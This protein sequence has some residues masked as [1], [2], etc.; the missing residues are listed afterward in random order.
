MTESSA[1]A[2]DEIVDD[3]AFLPHGLLNDATK[4]PQTK[5]VEQ[6]VTPRSM[7]KH[8]GEWLVDAKSRGKHKVKPEE[9]GEHIT[10]ARRNHLLRHEEDDVDEEEI[11]GDG[12]DIF[13]HKRGVSAVLKLGQG[14][15]ER[16]SEGM[17]KKAA[18]TKM[19]DTR[20]LYLQLRVYLQL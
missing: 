11:A 10:I 2:A 14:M 19:K 16:Y 3:E 15:I 12:R 9:F 1:N 8:V 7:E 17:D 20:K 6:D 13:E 18:N 4:H 5:H